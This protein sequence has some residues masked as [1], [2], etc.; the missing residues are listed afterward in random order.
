MIVSGFRAGLDLDTYPLS[1]LIRPPCAERAKPGRGKPVLFMH[2]I[3]AFSLVF[4]TISFERSRFSKIA[5]L[6]FFPL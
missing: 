6:L 1:E 2:I 5:T 3:L 4:H